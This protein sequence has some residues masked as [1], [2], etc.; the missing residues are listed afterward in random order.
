[1]ILCSRISQSLT[2]CVSMGSLY[3]IFC[4]VLWF[5]GT[6]FSA[7]TIDVTEDNKLATRV[8]VAPFGW[9]QGDLLSEDVAS[10]IENDFRLSGLLNPV[11][12]DKMLS[13]PTRQS[14]VSFR[15]WKILD[16]SYLIIGNV[17]R[18]NTVP[19]ELDT[20]KLSKKELKK[21][22]K[23]QAK[24]AKKSP[25]KKETTEENKNADACTIKYELYNVL[26]RKRILTGE[27]RGTVI[28]LRELAHYISDTVY[29]KITNFRGDFATRIM[30][31][32]VKELKKRDAKLE[33]A[34]N[35]LVNGAREKAFGRK[36]LD[37]NKK[38]QRKLYQLNDAD[39]DGHNPRVIFSSLE[40]LLSPAWSPD[41][42]EVAYVSF[43][44]GKA[45]IFIQNLNSG[46]R[47]NITRNDFVGQTSSP[48][49]SYNG[50]YLA[51]SVSRVANGEADIYIMKISTQVYYQ[52]TSKIGIDT[53]PTWMPDGD[54]I[55]FTSNRSNGVQIYQQELEYNL[56][57]G[58][59]APKKGSLPRRLTFEGNF[60][61]R[62]KTYPNGQGY[63][64]VHKPDS[65][66]RQSI[67]SQSFLGDRKSL[68]ILSTAMGTDS[69]SIGPGG[70][71][72]IYSIKG[73]NKKQGQLGMTSLD[74][75]MQ[76]VIPYYDTDGRILEV[77]EPAWGGFVEN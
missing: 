72:I 28:K 35:A 14:E 73:L 70:R 37:K 23:A 62:A 77:R 41:G 7:L 26:K 45:E 47:R 32:T 20:S 44:R 49:W 59:V 43:E 24:N 64:F 11:T 51:M 12:R 29:K 76:F 25:D 10:I 8:A 6:V 5:P 34:Q 53:E 68:Q 2:K 3:F 18:Y 38:D 40:P 69:P 48:M 16:V 4:L 54:S 58:D 9:R 46:K 50:K 75:N 60:N 61:A 57:S 71:R 15:D 65:R 19:T 52:I 27:V 22:K 74:G 63:V 17:E 33:K 56:V 21:H 1:M 36:F 39:A 66:G 67:V 13:L 30:Y 42:K 55:L 31:I